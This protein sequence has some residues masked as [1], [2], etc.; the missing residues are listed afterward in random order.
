VLKRLEQRGLVKREQSPS[1]GRAK[2]ACLTDE[3]YEV[4]GLMYAAMLGAQERF[5]APLKADERKKLMALL[6]VL[7]D[8]NN[9]LGRASM[10]TL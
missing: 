7:V 5:I 2:N 10:Q 1:D 8:S 3:G 9:E 4:T 6:R